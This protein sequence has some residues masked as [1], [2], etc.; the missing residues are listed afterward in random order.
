MILGFNLLFLIVNT[1]MFKSISCTHA[2]APNSE[3]TGSVYSVTKVVHATKISDGSTRQ[4]RMTLP[5][6][7]WHCEAEASVRYVRSRQSKTC[8]VE[9]I[10]ELDVLVPSLS[11]VCELALAETR[12][13]LRS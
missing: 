5:K 4:A 8:A 1:Y 12:N 3:R 6:I 10:I 11:Q 9:V 7:Q 13:R 2:P